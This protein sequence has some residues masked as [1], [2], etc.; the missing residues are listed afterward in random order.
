ME[1][2]RRSYREGC[3]CAVHTCTA[4]LWECRKSVP[5]GSEEPLKKHKEVSWSYWLPLK[6]SC[7][8]LQGSWK[9]GGVVEQVPVALRVCREVRLQSLLGNFALP[10]GHQKPKYYGNHHGNQMQK[11]GKEM[12][13]P[14]FL[15]FDSQCRI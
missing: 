14:C 5:L 4:I 11:R 9:P 12:M 10:S 6:T 3:V 8:Y 1:P 7:Q 13:S 2:F 15:S